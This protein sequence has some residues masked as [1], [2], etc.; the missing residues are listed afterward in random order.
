[1]EVINFTPQPLYPREECR[2]PL[3]RRLGGPQS[4]SGR[5]EQKN[6]LP[7]PEFDLRTFQQVSQSLYI[8]RY[9]SSFKKYN[10]LYKI[11]YE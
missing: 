2:Y 10:Q 3:N 1:M 11:S 5:W 7:L 6:L 8:P 4:L 9:P